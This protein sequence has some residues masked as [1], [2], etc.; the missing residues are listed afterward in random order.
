MREGGL[1]TLLS[2]AE[3]A[4]HGV[5]VCLGDWEVG[6]LFDALIIC[7]V[8]FQKRGKDTHQSS[9]CI[10]GRRFENCFA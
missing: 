7:I 8:T 5:G 3:N 2:E 9:C 6:R 1:K 4:Y 10:E